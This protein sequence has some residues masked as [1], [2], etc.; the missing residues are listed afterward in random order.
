MVL[1]YQ[2]SDPKETATTTQTQNQRY[3]LANAHCAIQF[4]NLKKFF[5]FLVVRRCF[6]VCNDSLKTVIKTPTEGYIESCKWIAHFAQDKWKESV[7]AQHTACVRFTVD[8]ERKQNWNS[9]FIFHWKLIIFVVLLS[10]QPK[11]QLLLCI[12]DACFALH[13]PFRMDVPLCF[14]SKHRCDSCA[15]CAYMNQVIWLP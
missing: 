6:L 7:G 11:S 3:L 2:A 1:L 4:P 9:M 15:N 10:L 12:C 8:N 5:F 14:H 13:L